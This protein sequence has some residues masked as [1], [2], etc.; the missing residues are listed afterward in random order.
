MKAVPP[1][2]KKATS[3]PSLAARLAN[4]SSGKRKSHSRSRPRK[5]AAA[6]LLSPPRPDMSGMRFS[7]LIVTP[8]SHLVA[9][10]SKLTVFETMLFSASHPARFCP[11]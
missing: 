11:A 1:Q 6:S 8:A 4:V 2:R 9:S 3:E 5:V 10:L 7:T